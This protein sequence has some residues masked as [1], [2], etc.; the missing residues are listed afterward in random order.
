MANILL[1]VVVLAGAAAWRRSGYW[2]PWSP[3]VAPARGR[4]LLVAGGL[5]ALL[6]TGYS[7]GD[8]LGGRT[9]ISKTPVRYAT[10]LHGTDAHQHDLRDSTRYWQQILRQTGAGLIVASA[11]VLLSRPARIGARLPA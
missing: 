1:A 9:Q 11:L 4:L 10:R 7:L 6:T 8:V 3:T 2:A 5:V